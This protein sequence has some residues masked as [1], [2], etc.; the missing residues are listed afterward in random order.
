VP[1]PNIIKTPWL[2]N[3]HLTFV[4]FFKWGE[5]MKNTFYI[6]G[7]LLFF[8]IGS[9]SVA[10]ADR[11]LLKDGTTVN[12]T[13][14][15]RDE[16]NLIVQGEYGKLTIP[17]GK[18]QSI[19]ME[20][21]TTFGHDT[22]SGKPQDSPQGN[23]NPAVAP[24]AESSNIS[25]TT[26]SEPRPNKTHVTDILS[27]N[28]NELAIGFETVNYSAP[29]TGTLTGTSVTGTAQTSLSQFVAG[30]K[31]GITDKLNIAFSLPV[32]EMNTI[33]ENL[34]SGSMT[35]GV[36]L[37]QSGMGDLTLGLR[38]QLSNKDTEG[39][40]WVAYAS[41]KPSTS[42]S[43]PGS[44]QVTVNGTV[45]SAGKNAQAGTG[46]VDYK[47]G[48]TL[49]SSKLADCYIDLN[50]FMPGSKTVSGQNQQNGN[51]LG[52]ELGMEKM[53]DETTTFTPSVWLDIVG[54]G[55]YTSNAS[56]STTNLGFTAAL[57]RDFS[58]AFS[59]TAQAQYISFG[60]VNESF[61]N[62]S[63]LSFGSATG[64]GFSLLGRFFF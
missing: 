52:M 62:G 57:T 47:V 49:S 2:G 29:F 30:Y 58:K 13:V 32:S 46:T 37:T 50:Y 25:T 38:Y 4:C 54:G 40:G 28:E 45:T 18:V 1:A 27:A 22:P 7:F 10:I 31:F 56:S 61:T 16:N 3:A 19:K 44:S 39:L 53:V 48:T 55:N 15:N 24:V 51:I 63:S 43:D 21:A 59:L 34:S 17:T 8:L 35:L 11:I 60:N 9:T 23:T 33:N 36:N 64:Y 20:E 14:I 12:G 41:V 42:G 5:A 6:F 26:H